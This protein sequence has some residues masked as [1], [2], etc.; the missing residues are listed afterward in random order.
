MTT[1]CNQFHQRMKTEQIGL[2]QIKC[3][4][5]NHTM[6][7]TNL[8]LSQRTSTTTHQYILHHMYRRCI[9]VMY[10]CVQVHS[11]FRVQLCDVTGIRI[12]SIVWWSSSSSGH[13][14]ESLPGS[15]ASGAS[16]LLSSPSR[17]TTTKH[18]R[19][20]GQLNTK[21]LQVQVVY[22]QFLFQ[23]CVASIS[24]HPTNQIVKKFNVRNIIWLVK[25]YVSR[26]THDAHDACGTSVILWTRL[27]SEVWTALPHTCISSS[28]NQQPTYT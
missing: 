15:T 19:E 9:Y 12:S 4:N 25:K 21:Q 2:L 8:D 22:S 28:H 16:Q 20:E 23:C 27:N 11:G 14:S 18:W 10:T 6:W 17:G 26:D 3:T 5:G 1:A 7:S 24:Q 13:C